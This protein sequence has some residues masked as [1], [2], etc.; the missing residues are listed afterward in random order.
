M[1]GGPGGVWRRLLQ[2]RSPGAMPD[3]WRQRGLDRES[4]DA[5][6]GRSPRGDVAPTELQSPHPPMVGE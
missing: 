2:R 5:L 4:I 6:L 3:C 1:S